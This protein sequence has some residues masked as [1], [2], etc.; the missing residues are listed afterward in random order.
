MLGAVRGGS[1]ATQHAYRFHGYRFNA[2]SEVRSVLKSYLPFKLQEAELNLRSVGLFASG[3][4]GFHVIV[5]IEV[6]LAKPP[7]TGSQHLPAIFKEIAID[8]FVDTLDLRVYTARRGR[9]LR[10]VNVKREGAG[11]YKVPLTVEEAFNMTVAD[12]SVIRSPC[13]L[14][15]RRIRWARKRRR[16]W[17]SA[18]A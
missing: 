10:T 17:R 16:C 12:Y 14:R 11:G 2:D 18:R 8:L 13:R 6:F 3:K 15:S 1:P 4:K 7:K 5:P 9:M